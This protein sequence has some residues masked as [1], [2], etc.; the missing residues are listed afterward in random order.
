MR[1]IRSMDKW[2]IALGLAASLGLSGPATATPCRDAP[3][4]KA[5]DF[6]IGNWTVVAVGD[7]SPQ[8]TSKIERVLDGCAVIENWQGASPGDDGKSL[9]SFDVRL[10]LWDQVWVTQDTSRPGGIKNKRMV[11]TYP[12]GGVRFQG[13]VF[14]APG[15]TMQD[16]TTLTPLP[17]GRVRQTIEISRDGGT[18]WSVGFD[19]YY[20]RTGKP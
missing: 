13:T 2:A 18:A 4:G 6:W 8:G 9:F 7:S 17:D 16:R 3:N 20:V 1:A 10:G 15:R 14:V 12:D 11:A 19:A 5:L